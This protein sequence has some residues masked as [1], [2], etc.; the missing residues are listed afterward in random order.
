MAQSPIQPPGI[1]SPIEVAAARIGE[2]LNASW[3]LDEVLG[4]GGMSTVFAGTHVSGRRAALKLLWTELCGDPDLRE[5]FLREGRIVNQIDHPGR[6]KVLGDDVS[7]RGE[8]F[9][10]MELLAGTT[11]DR[12]IRRTREA[13]P[14]EQA[15]AVFDAV[16][17]LLERCHGAGI[18]HRDIK[19]SNVFITAEGQV[20]VLDFGFARAREIDP[21]VTR[22]GLTYGTPAFMAPEQAMGIATV[23]GRADLWSVGACLY[24]ALS[25]RRLNQ[26]R[27]EAESYLLAAT[28]PA[29]S[30]ARAAPHLPVE[31]VTFVDRALAFDRARR[32]QDAA[33][34]RAEMRA[35]LAAHAAGR[36]TPGTPARGPGV[37]V[38]ANDVLHAPEPLAREEAAQ[39]VAA[40]WQKLAVVLGSARQY[41][42]SHPYVARGLAAVVEEISRV[43]AEDP[44]GVRWDVA[45]GAFM[46]FGQPVWQPDRPPL[47]RI[48]YQLFAD[49]I[50]NI[51]L[52]PGLTD[53]ELRDFA[54]ILLRD[55]AFGSD[56]DSITALWD[57]RFEHIAYLAVDSFTQGDLSR[58]ALD[59]ASLALARG[60]A[61]IDG[62]W[63][64]ES[65]EG[66]VMQR[67]L[68]AAL[69]D[70]G[71]GRAA[72][73]ASAAG[74]DRVTAATL[75]AQTGLSF[76][77]WRERWLDA[78]VDAYL[79]A[80]RRG[81]A[82]SLLAA[83]SEWTADQILLHNL[84]LAFEV[85][86]A[87]RRAFTGRSESRPD[88]R[89]EAPPGSMS[90]AQRAITAAMFPEASLRAIL[91]ELS[92]FGP[93]EP[94]GEDPSYVRRGGLP[95]PPPVAPG[96]AEGIAIALDAVPSGAMFAAVC[97]GYAG[98]PSERVR[99][100][101][102]AYLGRWAPGREAELADILPRAPA[103][104]ALT[105]LRLLSGLRTPQATAALEAALAS[106]HLE[107]RVSALALLPDAAREP[108]PQARAGGGDR[109][110]EEL[111]RLL[112]EPSTAV[113]IEALRTIARLGLLAAGPA[114]VRT[115]QA[116]AFHERPPEERREW[117]E[118][119]VRLN[120]TRA[121]RLAIELLQ[122]RQLLPT[123][124]IE[125][126]RE[127]AANVLAGFAASQDALDAVKEAT[128][129]RWSSSTKVR[130]AAA[131]AVTTI[132][133]RLSRRR[134]A[135]PAAEAAAPLSRRASTMPPP[136]STP[137]GAG[138]TTVPP[139]SMPPPSIPPP[140]VRKP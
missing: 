11:L 42:W 123:D 83:L 120:P 13:L 82:G 118:T 139:P 40:I 137:P 130:D 98:V 9:L 116:Q 10:V 41:G 23:D 34:M 4:A 33:V 47:D 1:A 14:L 58:E 8:P 72:A 17:D 39:R 78:F 79:E 55:R 5:R 18:I 2:R 134:S 25:G 101:L 60:L 53:L 43:L 131:R 100:V 115:I 19:P 67:N 85:H 57:R 49:G 97:E 36:L 95:P 27:T 29:P 52:K 117:L 3:R 133:A 69:R 132:A 46:A 93:D 44:A 81:D 99:E 54:A 26:G 128:K 136:P 125:Q 121:E 94:A 135:E 6:V 70:A 21:G 108:D 114:L 62:L 140:S 89:A 138:R 64:E 59:E 90:G 73:V 74:L 68:E 122:R 61:R 111:Q 96:V 51:Q 92:T 88:A 77:Q 127:I 50:R 7:D 65:L 129:S 45:P 48:P 86:A 76:E 22:V 71:A 66:R 80:T 16:L 56:E 35:L 31:V 24:V 75:G 124:A 107:V 113:R 20:K 104:L 105:V 109:V 106:P 15:L 110:R 12:L 37:V 119:V 112:D 38:R 126:T 84:A 30:L 63:D 87:L 102:L 103:P 32:F 91:E 28:Q